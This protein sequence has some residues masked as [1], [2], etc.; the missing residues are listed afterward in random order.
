[1]G[2]RELAW[3]VTTRELAT[4][5]EEERGEGDRAASYLLSPFGCRMNRVALAGELTPAEAI[6]REEASTFWR[7][8]LTDPT[9]AVAVTAG[10]F[11]PRAMAQLRASDAPRL[12]I[13]VG[14]AH[15]FR[16]RD[17]VGVVSVRAEGVRSV[18]ESEERGLLADV[19]RQTLDRLDLIERIEKD[20]MVRDEALREEGVPA[21]WIRAA[22]ESIRLYPNVDRPA[23]RRELRGAVR[24][25]GG[26]VG[27]D[28][29]TASPPPTVRV[30]RAPPPRAPAPPL[31]AADRQEESIFL[32]LVDEAS[33]L[34]A[35]G[36]ADLKE[37]LRRSA[38]RGLAAARAE[39]VLNRLEEGGVLEEP[40]VGKLRRSSA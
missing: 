28:A 27:A 16:G 24:R 30:T 12:A 35:D 21:P 9:G 20:R 7:A 32:D 36:Y 13:V 2:R 18:G 33:D 6:G 29:P 5:L 17:G 19:L 37:I 38:A 23:F 40:I 1:M 10:S 15:L 39:E 25:V 14:K 8:R 11:Q 26:G 22:R 31:S 3:R 4:A 34:S